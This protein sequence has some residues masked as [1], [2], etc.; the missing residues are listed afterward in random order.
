MISSARLTLFR[1]GPARPSRARATAFACAA[2]FAALVA[3]PVARAAQPPT[4]GTPPTTPQTVQ[5]TSAGQT[6]RVV[7][8]D[9]PDA[10]RE[11]LTHLLEQ[12]LR[13]ASDASLKAADRSRAE[14]EVTEIRRRLEV[15]DF[16][17]GDRFLLTVVADTVGRSEVL[18]REGPSIDF[19][20]LPALP[21]TGILRSELESAVHRHLARFYRTPEVRVQFLTRLTVVGAVARPGTYSVPP[22][23][24]LTDVMTT[25]AGGPTPS[26]NTDKIVVVR[27][28]REVVDEKAFRR[29][30]QEGQTVE[31][32][33]LQSGD[34]I[35]VGE[36]AR[37]NWGQIAMYSMFGVSVFTAVL[38][39][40][41]SSYSE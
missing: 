18:V 9:T 13:R 14:G 36:R 35:R 12:T 19:G 29:A 31:R 28:G 26:A 15:G 38:A 40:I 37:R 4:T 11:E 39:L 27:D 20:A 41:R 2:L 21:L 10:T 3:A 30:V 7:K 8:S 32:L 1:G 5:S 34:E 16:Q 23:L 17:P 25:Q 6:E 33:G 22:F 24:L